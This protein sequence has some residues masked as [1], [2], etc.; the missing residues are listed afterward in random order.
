MPLLLTDRYV[1]DFWFAPRAANEPYHLFFLQ[2]PRAIQ[3]PDLRHKL[4]TVGHAVSPD[5]KTWDVLPTAFE[6]GPAGAWDDQAIWT[7]SILK[8][9]ATYYFF[10]AA[11]HRASGWS[12]KIGFATSTDLLTWTRH[13]NNPILQPDPRWYETSPDAAV[14]EACRDAW[15]EYVADDPAFPAGVFYMFWTARINHGPLDE[16]GAIGFAR[17]TNLAQ[18]EQLPPVA[19]PGLY[20]HMEVPQP[21][22][23]NGRYYLFFCTNWHAAG[24]HAVGMDAAWSGTHYLMAER[25]LGPY[26][27][28]DH[29]PLL[30]DRSGTYYAG[31]VTHDPAG[32]PVFVAWR[33]WAVDGAFVG[34]ISDA[35][36][37]RV[38][39]DGQLSVD[40]RHLWPDQT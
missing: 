21:M 12:Q 35:A 29:P 20:G 17:S 32:K 22:L 34:G 3:H 24:S 5:L 14:G 23:I 1:W 28:V 30:A 19:A 16:R 33:Q 15:V 11:L 38:A 6:P 31:R 36:P 27:P 13:P 10:Y 40:T 39:P 37:L 9:H 25:L 2:A 7:G 26:Q 8:H 4:A 18:W